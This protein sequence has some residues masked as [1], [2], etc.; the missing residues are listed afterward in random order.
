MSLPGRTTAAIKSMALAAGL[1]IV[2][3]GIIF[4]SLAF[5]IAAGFDWASRRLAPAPAA[6]ATGC[7]LILFAILTAL[8]GRIILRRL[9]TPQP[10]LLSEFTTPLTTAARLSLMLIRRDPRKAVILATIAGALVEY[11]TSDSNKKA[12]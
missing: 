3:L 6:A 8:I 2:V 10:S 4:A 5:F 11:I 12:K 7:A 9:K 1:G